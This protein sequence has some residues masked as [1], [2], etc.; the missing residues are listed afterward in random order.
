MPKALVTGEQHPLVIVIAEHSVALLAVIRAIVA[1]IDSAS[2]PPPDGP[3]PPG[4]GASADAARTSPGS[5]RYQ[6]IEVTVEE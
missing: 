4:G 1:D 5:G 6:H 3:Q 2:Q